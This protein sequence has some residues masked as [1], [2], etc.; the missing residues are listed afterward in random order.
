VL[1]LWVDATPQKL[2]QFFKNIPQ[3]LREVQIE[4]RRVNWPSRE[5]T[6]RYTL[7]VIG[8]SAAIAALLGAFDFAF[9]SVLNR[10][11]F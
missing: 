11:I 4:L 1:S 5:E 8:L 2:M 10:F 7:I 3:F 6:I 9:A